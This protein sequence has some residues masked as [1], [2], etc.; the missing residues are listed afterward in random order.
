[1][2]IPAYTLKF[3]LSSAFF[4]QLSDVPGLRFLISVARSAPA[5]F[6]RTYPDKDDGP[7]YFS[8]VFSRSKGEVGFYGGRDGFIPGISSV[9][10]SSFTCF[11]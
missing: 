10:E 11:L 5:V 6:I 4:V 9:T 2:I 8:Y 1:M 7:V 3:S